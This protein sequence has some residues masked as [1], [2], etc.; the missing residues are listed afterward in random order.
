LVADIPPGTRYRTGH[1]CFSSCSQL[2]IYHDTKDSNT[3]KPELIRA[4]YLLPTAI[5]DASKCV[6]SGRRFAP[7]LRSDFVRVPSYPIMYAVEERDS[8]QRIHVSFWKA[9]VKGENTEGIYIVTATSGRI[10]KASWPI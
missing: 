8:I 2:I 3:Q 10:V 7:S 1:G 9:V 5:V 4:R 6:S